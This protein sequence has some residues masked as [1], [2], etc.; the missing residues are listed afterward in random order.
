MF[1]VLV[2]QT[3]CLYIENPLGYSNLLNVYY[4][5]L[6]E[7]ILPPK[8]MIIFGLDVVNKGP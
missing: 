7:N 8:K 3:P 5:K 2:L 6:N 1:H 4:N